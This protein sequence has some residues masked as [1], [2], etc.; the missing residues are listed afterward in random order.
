[1]FLVNSRL[2][3]F[4]ATS[5]SFGRKGLHQRRHP[6]SRSY[7]AILP[8]S[9]ARVSST[10]LESSSRLPVSVCGTGTGALA[11]GF[12]RKYGIS[13]FAPY[14]GAPH[15]LSELTP[16]RICLSWPPTGLAG[17][18]QSPGWPILL[19]PPIADNE[20]AV[21]R[22]YEPVVHRLRLSASA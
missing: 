20:H 17:H 16:G 18:I 9:L 7:G 4:A 13:H 1:V 2:S 10:A 15:H 8:S 3:L 22:E 5:L 19:R 6:F 11:R 12:S 14:S 21:V